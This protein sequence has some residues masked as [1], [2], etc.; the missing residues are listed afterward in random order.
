MIL[1]LSRTFPILWCLYSVFIYEAYSCFNRAPSSDFWCL[2][3]IHYCYTIVLRSFA[4]HEYSIM[5]QLLN[6]EVMYWER[7]LSLLIFTFDR[8]GHSIKN[9]FHFDISSIQFCAIRLLESVVPNDQKWYKKIA[10]KYAITLQLSRF[11]RVISFV[12]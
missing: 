9:I 5:L 8:K 12:R 11:N 1:F 7:L 3:K 10:V 6:K 4:P 2:L